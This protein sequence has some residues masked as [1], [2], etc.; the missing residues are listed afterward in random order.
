M[1][2]HV[3]HLGIAFTGD[4]DLLHPNLLYTLCGSCQYDQ[5]LNRYGQH[6][7]RS[8]YTV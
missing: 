4:Y 2:A 7:S 8:T 6:I 3:S 5:S 1:K